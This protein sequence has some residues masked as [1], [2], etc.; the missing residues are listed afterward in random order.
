MV[1]TGD[2]VERC[3]SSSQPSDPVA[4]APADS[5]SSRRDRML[6][7]RRI[8]RRRSILPRLPAALAPIVA[9]VF[10]ALSML[11]MM[12]SGQQPAR[13]HGSAGWGPRMTQLVE[14]LSAQA[15]A[16]EAA[17]GRSGSA[18]VGGRFGMGDSRAA[19]SK[20]TRVD[21]GGSGG[22]GSTVPSIA[23]RSET[24]R[25]HVRARAASGATSSTRRGRV[26]PP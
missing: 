22:A 21:R 25:G 11:M 2:E 23:R 9:A 18:S 19:V 12:L 16:R 17:S 3:T 5:R 20:P 10:A 7:R 8:P 4:K 24:V 15:G 1:K 13:K 6:R 26:T 14:Q